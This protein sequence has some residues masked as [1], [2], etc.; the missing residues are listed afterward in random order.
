VKVEACPLCKEEFNRPAVKTNFNLLGYLEEKQ[1]MSTIC[2]SSKEP[3]NNYC[4]DCKEIVC[5]ACSYLNHSEHLLRKPTLKTLGLRQAIFELVDQHEDK[6][7]VASNEELIAWKEGWTQ[8]IRYMQTWETNAIEHR[9]QELMSRIEE[10]VKTYTEI[11]QAATNKL[12]Q[13]LRLHMSS[14]ISTF[15]FRNIGK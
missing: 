7:E 5:D 9:K 15:L 6:R 3:E 4:L 1:G 14:R 10:A 8:R 2:K 11:T 13:R 12:L